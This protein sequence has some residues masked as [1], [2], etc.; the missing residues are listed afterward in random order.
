MLSENTK[1]NAFEKLEEIIDSHYSAYTQAVE[2]SRSDYLRSLPIGSTA[3]IIPLYGSFYTKEGLD[4][5]KSRCADS[6]SEASGIIEKLRA[7]VKAATVA[8]PSTEAVNTLMLLQM[9]T[10]ITEEECLDLLDKYGDNLQVYNAISD[11]ARKN[12]IHLPES[13]LARDAKDI[14]GAEKI[15]LNI[16]SPLKANTGITSGEVAMCKLGLDMMI[17]G[18]T[19]I[20]TVNTSED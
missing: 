11:I 8:A 5:F 14:E 3:R 18:I 20:K 6:R 7:D 4:G 13:E 9:R 12:K 2:Q 17:Q 15:V 19:R 10:T 16:L 1:K